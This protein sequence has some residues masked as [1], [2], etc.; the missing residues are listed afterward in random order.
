MSVVI[1]GTVPQVGGFWSWLSGGGSKTTKE[2]LQTNDPNAI[3]ER[4]MHFQK[5]HEDKDRK[6]DKLLETNE[7]HG[8]ILAR[9]L[10]GN[11]K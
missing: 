5:Y 9:T 7:L 11:M 3:R 6:Y 4:Y 8:G 10:T 1:T 2:A